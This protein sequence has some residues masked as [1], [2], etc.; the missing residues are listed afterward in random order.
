MMY[1]ILVRQM[2]ASSMCF[3]PVEDSRG[4]PY[5]FLLRRCASKYLAEPFFK[6]KH[7]RIVLFK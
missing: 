1:M 6:D 4:K 5:L 2:F 7:H 3:L